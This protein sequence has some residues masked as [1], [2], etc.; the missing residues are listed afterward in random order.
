MAALGQSLYSCAKAYMAPEANNIYCPAL[1]NKKIC[2]SLVYKTIF[3]GAL[4]V[5]EVKAFCTSDTK[6]EMNLR[7][8]WVS[9]YF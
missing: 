8:I 5:T 3:C 9:K 6:S 2:Q 7:K 4:S 1:Y